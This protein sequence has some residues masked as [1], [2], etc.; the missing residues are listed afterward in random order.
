MVPDPHP[1]SHIP[2]LAVIV[3]HRREPSQSESLCS[4]VQILTENPD[5]E[6]S[7]S[8]II[9]DN[10]PQ[11]QDCEVAANFPVPVLY[12]HDPTNPGLA[13]AYNF[14]LDYA[15]K[16]R[17]EWLLLLDQDTPVTYG[18]LTELIACA[19]TLRPQPQVGAIVPKLLV[20]GKIYSPLAHFIDHLRHQYRRS[21]HAVSRQIVGLQ[22]RRLTAYNSG[23]TFR[24]LALQSI[25][26]FPQEYWLDYLDH[27]VFHALFVRGYR[28]YVLRSEIKHDASQA[29]MG[30]VPA[31][32]QRNL[33]SAQG[34]FVQQT[35]SFLDRLLYRI[36]LLRYSSSLWIRHPD[37]H[38]WKE[39]LL[40][41]VSLTGRTDPLPTSRRI[42]QNP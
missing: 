38:L 31:W 8:V 4:L 1:Q 21:N 18:F 14:A 41:A 37:K 6:K 2:V 7:F 19:K 13:T 32:R 11:R 42:S 10:S 17:F 12:K 3:L 28:T 16:D 27:A 15:V 30:Q 33:L 25:G 26:G 5:L 35:G 36:W 40:R 29:T 34:R 22:D 23:A 24:V 39:A 20:D 9:Y